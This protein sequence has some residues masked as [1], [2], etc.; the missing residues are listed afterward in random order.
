M[1]SVHRFHT[2]S[3]SI[4]QVADLSREIRMEGDYLRSRERLERRSGARF[5]ATKRR[6]R[7]QQFARLHLAV[8][9]DV[10]E[11]LDIRLHALEKIVEA[12][13]EQPGLPCLRLQAKHRAV[14]HQ[15]LVAYL[16]LRK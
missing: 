3:G 1:R 6:I 10:Q 8:Q 7:M 11:F 15:Q 2:D 14:P 13:R 9:S 5:Q 4:R 12:V 16:A